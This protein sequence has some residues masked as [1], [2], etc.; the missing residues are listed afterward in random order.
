MNVSLL[1]EFIPHLFDIRMYQVYILK[2]KKDK[3]FYVGYTNDVQRRLQEHNKGLVKYTQRH[4]P[5]DLVYYESFATIEDA[6]LRESSLKH[7][8]RHSAN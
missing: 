4:K 6:R 2:S 8:V 1:A 7:F 3:C 5:W